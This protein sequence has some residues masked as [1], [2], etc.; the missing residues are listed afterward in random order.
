MVCLGFLL[1]VS[2]F[3]NLNTFTRAALLTY[4]MGQ[5]SYTRVGH[6]PREPQH[7]REP[8]TEGSPRTDPFLGNPESLTVSHVHTPEVLLPHTPSEDH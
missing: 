5:Q 1:E 6:F 3:W 7:S 2:V 8:H 4:P